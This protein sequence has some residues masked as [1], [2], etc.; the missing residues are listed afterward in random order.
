MYI[1]LKIVEEVALKGEPVSIICQNINYYMG[2]TRDIWRKSISV[3]IEGKTDVVQHHRSTLKNATQ[4]FNDQKLEFFTY[5]NGFKL[6][7]EKIMTGQA[8]KIHQGTGPFIIKFKPTPD[9]VTI[10]NI[11]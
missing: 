4:S 11:E 7:F 1:I 8:D 6:G 3:G 10:V 9:R 5:S 2:G